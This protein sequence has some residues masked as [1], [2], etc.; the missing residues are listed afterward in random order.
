MICRYLC[1]LYL[2]DS[3]ANIAL[4]L[5]VF[6]LLEWSFIVF[7]WLSDS[8]VSRLRGWIKVFNSKNL[9]KIYLDNSNVNIVVIGYSCFEDKKKVS[10][11][12]DYFAFCFLVLVLVSLY[13]IK[14]CKVEKYKKNFNKMKE[15]S[16]S[17]V[18]DILY[19]Y[20][21]FE[22]KN[23][24]KGGDIEY[25]KGNSFRRTLGLLKNVIINQL[26][27]KNLY[28]FAKVIKMGNG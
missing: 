3:I 15:N 26:T 21:E 20:I 4:I 23:I 19:L 10:N 28:Y 13:H 9:Q 18:R 1:S 16:S 5:I 2:S 24:R 7:F 14:M 6:D 11:M 12:R 17:I 27:R 25:Q 8:I 22:K